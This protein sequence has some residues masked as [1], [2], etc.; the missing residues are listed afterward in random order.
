MNNK[1]KVQFM[2]R[3]KF[4]F[5]YYMVF[6]FLREKVFLINYVFKD[7]QGFSYFMKQLISSL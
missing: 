3:S 5:W 1:G 6:I 7:L 4:F 2:C